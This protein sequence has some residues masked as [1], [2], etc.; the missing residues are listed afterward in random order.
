MKKVKALI[1]ACIL[2]SLLTGCVYRHPPVYCEDVKSFSYKADLET[3][4]NESPNI[5]DDG[6]VNTSELKEEIK[7][8]TEAI[9]QAAKECP[10]EWDNYTYYY[11]QTSKVWKIEFWDTKDTEGY[12][13]YIYQTVYL[14]SLGVTLLIVYGK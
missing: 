7:W 11:D 10:I 12:P 3:Y 5:K 14:N 8:H 4:Q 1:L 13:M 9:E 6:F 2:T